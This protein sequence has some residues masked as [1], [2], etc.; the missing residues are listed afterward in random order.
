MKVK[1]YAVLKDGSESVFYYESD[2]I[3]TVGEEIYYE[4]DEEKHQLIEFATVVK[5][6]VV[7]EFLNGTRKTTVVLQVV[8]QMW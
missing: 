6:Q 5:R 2:F 4:A 1:V 3:P 7:E 8:E